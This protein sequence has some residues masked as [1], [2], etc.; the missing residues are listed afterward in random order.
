MWGITPRPGIAVRPLDK[1]GQRPNKTP[2]LSSDALPS[3]SWR[4]H[5][6][7]AEIEVYSADDQVELLLNGR[8][9]G[10]RSAG[11]RKGYVARFRALYEPGEL[12]AIAYRDGRESGRS[13]LRS[14]GVPRL[15]LRAET[16]EL[17]GPDDL[18]YVWLELADEDGIVDMGSDDRI[19]VNVS[20]SGHPRRP[21]QRR[22]RDD[23]ELRR[24]RDAPRTVAA[25]SR[26]SGAVT[27]TVRS[28][29]GRHLHATARHPSPCTSPPMPQSPRSAS[30]HPGWSRDDRI[31]A[32]PPD[33]PD[34]APPSPLRTHRRVAIGRLSDTRAAALHLRNS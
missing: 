14:A 31:R 32:D 21:R 15:R 5:A 3:W 22:T 4:G 26:S 33:R 2:W 18:A 30:P 27:K 24:R 7:L 16:D 17:C 9:L 20:G 12:T 34:S 11:P 19:A 28:P 13:T 6:G 25:R 23:G 8:S 29:S 10:R 1:T